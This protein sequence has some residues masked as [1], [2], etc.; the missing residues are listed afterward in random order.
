MRDV[1]YQYRNYSD[2]RP[3]QK[4][5]GPAVRPL[6]GWASSA[7]SLRRKPPSPCPLPTHPDAR[8]YGATE[9]PNSMEKMA[10]KIQDKLHKE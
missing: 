3:R 10:G 4:A 9:L 7:T 8:F 5:P 1:A 2:G 6:T